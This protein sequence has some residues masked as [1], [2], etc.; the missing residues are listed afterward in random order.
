M[1][2][3]TFEQ[4]VHALH[5]ARA[6]PD[7][8]EAHGTLAG[9]LCVSSTYRLRDWL[10]EIL[11]DKLPDADA[12]ATLR[13]VYQA[14]V[15]ALGSALSGFDLLLP[16]DEV[17][18]GDRTAALGLWCQGFLYGLGSGP[19]PDPGSVSPQAQE[20][21]ADFSQIT[22]VAVDDSED[23]ETNEAAFAE[24]V[25]FVRVAAQLLFI[26]LAAER[27]DPQLEPHATMH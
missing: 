3:V 5:D 19:M 6:L 25:E 2:P 27:R 9:A 8:P 24:V 23:A 20:I 12:P 22:Q 17:A 10:I 21:V 16:G 18:L 13:E 26:E 15:Q 1:L 7:A 14:T 4:F 11:P